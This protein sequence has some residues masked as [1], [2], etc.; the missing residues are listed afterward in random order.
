MAPP[1]SPE[2]LP[3]KVPP[4]TVSAPS[5][6]LSMAPPS[7]AAAPLTKFRPLMLTST[8]D[9]TS[10]RLKSGGLPVRLRSSV[11]ANPRRVRSVVMS[12]RALI[13]TYVQFDASIIISPLNAPAR[14]V[15]R[16]VGLHGT[17]TVP[18]TDA[19]AACA[20]SG[21][22]AT[23]SPAA[24]AVIIVLGNLALMYVSPESNVSHLTE[25]HS[26]TG[27]ASKGL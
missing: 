13:S 6:S 11:D 23:A 7:S 5:S 3:E 8:A 27:G 1:Y 14:S 15:A 12:G 18:D 2:V 4:D 21:P 16:V 24:A 9:V 22:A 20:A 17:N 19:D 25:A 26:Y 10:R